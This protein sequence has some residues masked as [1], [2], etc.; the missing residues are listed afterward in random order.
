MFRCLSNLVEERGRS[1][2]NSWKFTHQPSLRGSHCL[3]SCLL[4]ML[5]CTL[6][7]NHSFRFFH[8]SQDHFLT[9]TLFILC[10]GQ[11]PKNS[12]CHEPSYLEQKTK[13]ILE[14]IVRTVNTRMQVVIENRVLESMGPSLAAGSTSHGVGVPP[15]V[16]NESVSWQRSTHTYYKLCSYLIKWHI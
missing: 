10:H 5:H 15:C 13:F 14:S 2:E 11:K 1:D 3:P 9:N 6:Q 8:C 4:L 7:P 12:T 16:N